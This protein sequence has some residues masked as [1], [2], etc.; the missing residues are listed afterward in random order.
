MSVN[1]TTLNLY[2]E[3]KITWPLL[4]LKVCLFPTF[5]KFLDNKITYLFKIVAMMEFYPLI[6]IGCEHQH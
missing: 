5:P 3:V 4:A 2:L 1:T 6:I